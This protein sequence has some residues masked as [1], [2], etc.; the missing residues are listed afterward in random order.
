MALSPSL[1]HLLMTWQCPVCGHQQQ[2]SGS[3]IQSAQ[4]IKCE[5]CG[6]RVRL[7][8]ADKV[9]LFDRHDPGN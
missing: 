3:W 4:F 6:E 9:A 8:Y 7:T 1:Y 5:S 2:K